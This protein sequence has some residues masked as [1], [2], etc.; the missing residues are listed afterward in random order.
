MKRFLTIVGL[1]LLAATTVEAQFVRDWHVVTTEH[2]E[3]IS[4]YDPVKHGEVTS[5]VGATS[6]C[7]RVAS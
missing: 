3:L 5:G 4:R 7:V 6:C 2:F 1:L